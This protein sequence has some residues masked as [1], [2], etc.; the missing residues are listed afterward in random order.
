MV[1]QLPPQPAPPPTSRGR[2]VRVEYLDFQ[3]LAEHRQYRFCAQ[4]PDGWAEFRLR[5]ELAAFGA[6]GVRLQD[7]PDVC[8]GKLLLAIAGGELPGAEAITI[9]DADLASYR[10]AHTHAPKRRSFSD[11]SPLP[12]SAAA[13]ASAQALPRPEV[14]PT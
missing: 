13:L 7:G 3:N 6:G 9:D 12:P 14:V 8:Y 2:F 4:S 5:I 1:V 10:A 11:S